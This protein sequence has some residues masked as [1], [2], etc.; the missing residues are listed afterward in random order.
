MA[1]NIGE[2]GCLN[3]NQCKGDALCIDSVCQCPTDFQPLEDN[4]RCAKTGGKFHP[5]HLHTLNFLFYQLKSFYYLL[6]FCRNKMRNN[7]ICFL[8]YI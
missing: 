5:Q 7:I 2:A 1:G 3:D 4:T 8:N 6:N